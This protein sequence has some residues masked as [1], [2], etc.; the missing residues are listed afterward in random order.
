[1]IVVDITGLEYQSGLE[2]LTSHIKRKEEI[3]IHIDFWADHKESKIIRDFVGNIFD[4]FHVGNPWKG[5]FILITDELINNAIEHGSLP[6]DM[7]SCVIEAKESE[8]WEFSITIEVH[9]TGNGKDSKDATHMSDIKEERLE[10][11][12]NVYMEKRWRW[13]FYITEKI[14]DRLSFSESPQGWLAVKVEKNIMPI[15]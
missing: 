8:K 12:S 1:M 13:L 7:D 6:W 15:L 3:K 14:V 11:D 10:K 5:R 9:D 2:V 4:N